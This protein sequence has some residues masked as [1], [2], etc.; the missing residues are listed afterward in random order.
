MAS[1]T[2]KSTALLETFLALHG[3]GRRIVLQTPH[4]LVLPEVVA[5]TDLIATVPLAVASHLS[6]RADIP[7][8]FAL[9]ALQPRSV[10]RVGHGTLA[11][12][13]DLPVTG[14]RWC[15]AS[16]GAA[17]HNTGESQPPMAFVTTG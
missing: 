16:A 10:R 14:L 4:H 1:T 5:R 2:A 17:I 8:G 7:R 11:A 3:I 9:L 15:A 12:C 13:S 6:E